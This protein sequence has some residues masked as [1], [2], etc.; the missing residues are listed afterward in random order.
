MDYKEIKEGLIFYLPEKF[1]ILFVNE[2]EVEFKELLN[3][4]KPKKIVFDMSQTTYL[5]SA[6]LRLL[7][8]SCKITDNNVYILKA[9]EIIRNIIKVTGFE[10]LFK[11][12]D[13]YEEE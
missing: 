13:E 4:K 3:S 2:W 1:D 5:S 7:L 10:N 6:A 12:V 11:F 9:N 8:Y